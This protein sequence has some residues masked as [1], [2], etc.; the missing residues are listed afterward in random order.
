MKP[1]PPRR[2]AGI[3]AR[4]AGQLASGGTE[5]RRMFLRLLSP[6]V[7]ERRCSLCADT[8]NIEKSKDL[9]RTLPRT[10]NSIQERPRVPADCF[11]AKT[12]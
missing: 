4:L 9:H 3:D 11:H 10:A 6:P 12:V 1:V 7:I 8:N 2:R 5:T